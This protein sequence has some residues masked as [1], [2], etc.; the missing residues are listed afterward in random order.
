MIKTRICDLLGVKYP[1][2]EGGMGMGQGAAAAAAISNAGALGCTGRPPYYRAYLGLD[3][4][5]PYRESVV[6]MLSLTDKPFSVNIPIGTEQLDRD[7][8]IDLMCEIKR[9]DPNANKQFVTIVTSGGNGAPYVDIIKSAGFKHIHK[10]ST[11][12][13]A[14]KMESAGVDALIALSY[15][16]GGHIGFDPVATLTL[17]PTI[18]ESVKIPVI[19]AGGFCDGAGL[20]AALALGAEGIEMG[21]RFLATKEF[22]V[23][24]RYKAAVVAAEAKDAIV[25]IGRFGNIRYIMNKY[26]QHRIEESGGKSEDQ[27]SPELREKMLKE[28][29][30]AFRRLL[31]DKDTDLE[32]VPL[33][34]GPVA[35]RIK[36]I[37][38]AGEVVTQ[39]VREAE[40]IIANLSSRVVRES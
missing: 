27:L 1:I 2:I 17:L 33:F 28:H 3:T 25:S 9:N 21:T 32:W 23:N 36:S 26:L 16:G 14:Q 13:Q 7:V 12:R 5:E 35:G 22:K 4:V 18:V 31:E 19:G 40:Q 39:I 34:A 11:V 29:N 15:E 8:L 24:P 10:V 20:V 30:D 38:G 37:E 6:E